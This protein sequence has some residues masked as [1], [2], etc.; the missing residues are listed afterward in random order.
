[1]VSPQDNINVDLNSNDQGDQVAQQ[2]VPT[3]CHTT[4]AFKVE[5]SKVSEIFRQK[6]KDMLSAIN[7]IWHIDD[8]TWTKK[9]E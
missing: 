5:Q 6:L 1:V 3:R 2:Q 8:L 9:L 4:L 7:F